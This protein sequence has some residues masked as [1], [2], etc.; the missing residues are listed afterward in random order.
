[1][2]RHFLPGIA[3][4]RW[5]VPGRAAALGALGL[6]VAVGLAACSGTD[7]DY[8]SCPVVA[9][10]GG[11]ERIAQSQDE[12]PPGSTDVAVEAAIE[13]FAARCRHSDG[14]VLVRVAFDIVAQREA[15]ALGVSATVP[16]FVS[17]TDAEGQVVAK[18]VFDSPLLFAGGDAT[19]R[20]EKVEQEILLTEGQD[21]R[22]FSVFVGFQLTPRQLGQNL[23][24]GGG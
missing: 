16:F 6:A 5:R 22:A 12:F 7:G 2:H 10:V 23:G 8:L 11:T 4:R 24:E 21:A 9:I 18:T 15:A 1:M 20:S 13:Q 14:S 3:R 19:V 17:V